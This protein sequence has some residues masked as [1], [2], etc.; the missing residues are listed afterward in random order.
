[1]TALS[2]G[3]DS[4]GLGLIITDHPDGANQ[5]IAVGGGAR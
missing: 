2:G 3:E 5:L 4:V 1:V